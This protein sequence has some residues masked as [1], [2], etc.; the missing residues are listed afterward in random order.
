MNEEEERKPK[1]RAKKRKPVSKR[2]QLKRRQEFDIRALGKGEADETVKDVNAQWTR[3]Y[4]ELWGE[5]EAVAVQR[6]LIAESPTFLFTVFWGLGFPPLP[7]GM[8]KL[9]T[10][11]EED[12]SE[13]FSTFSI[14]SKD[15]TQDHKLFLE[16]E[17]R[18]GRCAL[19]RSR[20][21]VN[22]IKSLGVQADSAVLD[23][24][25]D[26]ESSE[27][28]QR[29]DE[30]VVLQRKVVPCFDAL[31]AVWQSAWSPSPVVQFDR[32]LCRVPNS[33]DGQMRT[34]KEWLN[35]KPSTARELSVLQ[36]K[37]ALELATKFLAVGGRMAYLTSSI[38]PLENQ[39]VVRDLVA[40]CQGGLRVVEQAHTPV[41]EPGGGGYYCVLEK[42]GEIPVGPPLHDAAKLMQANDCLSAL[43]NSSCLGT[44]VAIARHRAPKIAE[45]PFV[46]EPNVG[47]LQDLKLDEHRYDCLT[48]VQGKE[49]YLCSAAVASYYGLT[50][51]GGADKEQP[52]VRRCGLLLL[53]ESDA[54]LEQR[55]LVHVKQ[56]LN[57]VQV[58][59]ES[60]A[61]QTLRSALKTKTVAFD[62][63]GMEA[64]K[65]ENYY[66]LE[67][68]YSDAD[69]GR[70]HS[71]HQAG[72]RIS[73][74]QRKRMKRDAGK[75]A[76]TPTATTSARRT[77]LLF[78]RVIFDEEDNKLVE[79]ANDDDWLESCA[80]SMF[81]SL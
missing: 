56:G 38:N 25:A 8:R 34:R 19:K 5:E 59:G 80:H 21:V 3:Y 40:C 9:L 26:E 33:Q 47:L 23:I 64:D 2:T 69:A 48:S 75:A 7:S 12:G 37:I 31:T 18:L 20:T 76:V 22:A 57:V 1:D 71:Q 35:W 61:S 44:S 6:G 81:S 16:R 55:A 49:S 46:V 14:P 45:G 60:L 10:V 43:K 63:L 66:V 53:V 62:S 32:I 74:A 58:Q 78:G 42:L 15:L 73:T 51:E 28:C 27:L 29:T 4:Q 67:L 39:D 50:V 17:S 13:R 24:L 30:L 77:C 54:P 70:Q 79:I 68:S 72:E 41:S 36:L 52:L 65:D 11:V